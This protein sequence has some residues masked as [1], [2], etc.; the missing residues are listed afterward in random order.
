[1][2]LR[3]NQLKLQHQ[4]FTMTLF[5]VLEALKRIL[6]IKVNNSKISCFTTLIRPLEYLD[7]VPPH[8]TQ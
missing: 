4:R 3:A 5:Y 8:I 2:R 6:M 7:W 1:M